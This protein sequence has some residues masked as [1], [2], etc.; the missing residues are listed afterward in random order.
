MRRGN[1]KCGVDYQ[2]TYAVP[3]CKEVADDLCCSDQK[4]RVLLHAAQERTRSVYVEYL[5]PLCD[6][7]NQLHYRLQDGF[8]ISFVGHSAMIRRMPSD[9][10][11]PLANIA[12]A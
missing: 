1:S 12:Y 9:S 4:R 7:T 5:P 6:Q 2:G 3:H 10:A 8:A 11:G